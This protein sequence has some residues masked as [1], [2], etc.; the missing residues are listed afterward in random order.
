MAESS[1]QK[2][3]AAPAGP[4]FGTHCMRLAAWS[5]ELERATQAT[6][7][8]LGEVLELAEALEQH[9]AWEPFSDADA[10]PNALAAVALHHMRAIADHD[11][12]DAVKKLPV[13]PVAA[14]RALRML[15]REDWSAADLESVA[16]S[17]P[18][19]AT[20]L[21]GAA[22][23]WTY[24]ARHPIGT[25]SHAV[26]YIGSQQAARILYAA[27]IKPLFASGA[28]H[29]VWHH[30]LDA[31]QFAHDLGKAVSL[32]PQEAFLAGLI[33]DIGRLAIATL[34]AEYQARSARLAQIGC[35][36]QLIER[37]LC[38]MSHAR[39]GAM[40]LKAWG[41]PQHLIEAVEFHHEPERSQSKMAAL[42]YLTESWIDAGEDVSYLSRVN[43][44]L[45]R[46]GLTQERFDDFA[47]KSNPGLESYR[48][49]AR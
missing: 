21:I 17:D 29:E 15:L 22:N 7:E 10:E 45:Q 48:F 32:D 33:H 20:Q 11:L 4:G 1:T 44:A 38:G 12:D 30:S 47:G 34:P 43:A 6:P 31:A 18:S 36:T 8:Q 24:A 28:M 9:F 23:S 14:Q 25:L 13:L 19:L 42:L 2:T 49:S 37:A 26:A 39:V 40:A 27:S 35:E 5:I 41:F 3:P 46:L 16:A